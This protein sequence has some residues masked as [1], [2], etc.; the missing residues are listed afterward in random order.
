MPAA[1]HRALATMMT[2]VVRAGDLTVQLSAKPGED[3]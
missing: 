2:I 3:H 1:L